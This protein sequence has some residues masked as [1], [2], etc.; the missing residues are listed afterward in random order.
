MQIPKDMLVSRARTFGE[1][2]VWLTQN[3]DEGLR[4][5]KTYAGK[6]IAVSNKNVV[7]GET[8]VRR[9]LLELKK[10]KYQPDEI[11]SM[12]IEYVSRTKTNLII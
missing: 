2:A 4:L 3:L 1:D 6:Y 8:N 9:L 7:A 12:V 5:R 11:G 10:K